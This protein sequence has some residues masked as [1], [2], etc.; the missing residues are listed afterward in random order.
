VVLQADPFGS[1]FGF[2]DVGAPAVTDGAGGFAFIVP[3]MQ[4][5]T[6]YRIVVVASP[7]AISPTVTAAVAVRVSSRVRH[8]AGPHRVRFSG[9][10][11]PAENGDHV[12]ILRIVSGRGVPVAAAVLH[13]DGPAR[14]SFFSRTVRV[15][16][17]VYRVLA[18]VA[19]AQV[20]A[21]GPPLLI[22]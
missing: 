11:T 17:G 18:L 20:S 2:I 13:P 1:A 12:A 8:G 22:R 7:P 4:S 21:Y 19:G 3:G 10:V 6:R 5:S 16:P 9:T 15:R 14:S